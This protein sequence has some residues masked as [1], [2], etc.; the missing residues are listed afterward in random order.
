M[1]FGSL[2][3]CQR[4]RGLRHLR[5]RG[6]RLLGHQRNGVEL[7][8]IGL[9]P[10]FP[11]GLQGAGIRRPACGLIALRIESR[12]FPGRAFGATEF[13]VNVCEALVLLQAGEGAEAVDVSIQPSVV[14]SALEPVAEQ[15]AQRLSLADAVE[16]PLGPMH[17]FGGEV[18]GKRFLA[19]RM[20]LREVSAA[21]HRRRRGM[22]QRGCVDIA[23]VG[24][25][26]G[27]GSGDSRRWGRHGFK[28]RRS[29]DLFHPPVPAQ[30]DAGGIGVT[31]RS[32]SSRGQ[33]GGPG[34]EAEGGQVNR[35]REQRL[36]GR[37]RQREQ[38]IQRRVMRRG[39]RAVQYQIAQRSGNER[40]R[41][42]RSD[43]GFRKFTHR[44][45]ARRGLLRQ[46]YDGVVLRERME[47]TP[48][49]VTQKPALRL[50]PDGQRRLRIG[51]RL[52]H[53]TVE[54]RDREQAIGLGIDPERGKGPGGAHE[55]REMC[56]QKFCA[57]LFREL[58]QQGAVA[59][60]EQGGI[61]GGGVALFRSPGSL[62]MRKDA[63]GKAQGFGRDLAVRPW[64]DEWRSQF[65]LQRLRCRTPGGAIAGRR[66][67]AVIGRH[68]LSDESET[69]GVVMGIEQ[70]GQARCRGGR[71]P[72]SFCAEHD[73]AIESGLRILVA[74]GNPEAHADG[75]GGVEVGDPAHAFVD[76]RETVVFD[77]RRAARRRP[78]GHCLGNGFAPGRDVR[79]VSS[80]A[81]GDPAVGQHL[82]IGR[83]CPGVVA[84]GDGLTARRIERIG[85]PGGACGAEPLRELL[86]GL[87]FSFQLLRPRRHGRDLLPEL[88]AP[89]FL[90]RGHARFMAVDM[91]V[92]GVDAQQEVGSR[93]GPARGESGFQ[94]H[95]QQQQRMARGD[96]P[97]EAVGAEESGGRRIAG[98][99]VFPEPGGH[100]GEIGSG[101]GDGGLGGQDP[102]LQ[103]AEFS[104]VEPLLGCQRIC[105][106]VGR[107]RAR[108]CAV[109][110]RL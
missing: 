84:S 59:E 58:P 76:G 109:M 50:P 11:L 56:A 12:D 39:Q 81:D 95:R 72:R 38:R 92:V 22:T 33:R 20:F 4:L 15:G 78:H 36:T 14:E 28:R 100:R 83:A 106:F 103:L 82:R 75:F 69:A 73:D 8:A 9:R 55:L 48:G 40:A 104:L 57:G 45:A 17:P 99:P 105:A 29:P 3:L 37:F 66:F 35:F 64:L 7:E 65:D 70:L 90:L 31:Q 101:T 21:E 63:R 86:P 93:S 30:T 1:R 18:H 110:F 77:E 10:A 6:L 46:H 60:G 42:G 27:E 41:H 2:L 54:C 98:A 62:H 43:G 108:H 24:R 96:G 47:R 34:I 44:V 19:R 25:G 68:I 13:L 80:I 97:G 16:Q 85:N 5:I 71:V 74:E 52:R 88:G 89:A 61:H 107:L 87:S 32:Q 53:P 67:R 23:F 79:S 49:I 91:Y 26:T 51:S 102:G 94:S